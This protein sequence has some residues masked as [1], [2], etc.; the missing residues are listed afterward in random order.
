MFK[1]KNL[2]IANGHLADDAVGADELA[3]NAVVDASVAGNAAIAFSKLAALPSTN[4]LVGS[5]G[6]AATAVAMSGDATLANNGVLTIANDAVDGN[7]LA[8]DITIANDLVV[9]RNL[10]VNGTTTTIST[11]QIE[12]EDKDLVLGK[13]A[14][15]TDVTADQGGLILTSSAGD[16]TFKW[17]NA[18]DSWTS[19]QHIELSDAN[20]GFRING[21]LVMSRTSLGSSV[22]TSDLTTL[23]AMAETLDMSDED[24]GDIKDAKAT[25]FRTGKGSGNYAKLSALTL[26]AVGTDQNL[27]ILP[28]GAGKVLVTGLKNV[29]VQDNDEKGISN[30]ANLLFK[31]ANRLIQSDASNNIIIDP[32]GVLLMG[33]GKHL[34][35]GNAACDLGHSGGKFRNIYGVNVHAGD[36]HLKNARGAWRLIEE[37]SFLSIRNEKT[38]KRYKF[39][40]TLL[41]DDEWD[42]DNNWTAPDEE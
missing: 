2:G 12:V 10:T 15:P 34:Y 5:A 40:M 39:N 19:N 25:S 11:T 29:T 18:T 28:T 26:E 17:I 37:N 21:A 6:N 31:G 16:K 3:A 20:G 41:P 7:K 35:P 24:I 13:V 27:T 23:G 36:L 22:V 38:G 42:P 32:G 1:V 14:S 8:N 9:T 4:I 30:V 33:N